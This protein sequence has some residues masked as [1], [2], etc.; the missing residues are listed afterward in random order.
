MQIEIFNKKTVTA[1]RY[2]IQ[3][4]PF[5]EIVRIECSKHLTEDGAWN[6]TKE[7]AVILSDD[8]SFTQNTNTDSVA[9]PDTSNKIDWQRALENIG[10]LEEDLYMTESEGSPFSQLLEQF[11]KHILESEEENPTAEEPMTSA[12]DQKPAEFPSTN[13]EQEVHETKKETKKRKI[14]RE[15]FVIVPRPVMKRTSEEEIDSYVQKYDGKKYPVIDEQ[16]CHAARFWIITRLIEK[17][18]KEIS[19]RDVARHLNVSRK[20]FEKRNRLR[21]KN[22]PKFY[23]YLSPGEANTK[24]RASIIKI[25]GRK[26]DKVKY[27]LK[28]E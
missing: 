24:S 20:M 6:C 25:Y 10:S 22:D 14:Q 19:V 15:E 28:G 11:D 1:T 18:D 17:Y 21:L 4:G 2:T 23:N 26:K 16:L 5:E 9:N 7:M 12:L 3:T 13:K 8:I 27:G